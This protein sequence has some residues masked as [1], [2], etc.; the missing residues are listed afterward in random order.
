MLKKKI[1]IQRSVSWLTNWSNYTSEHAP[2]LLK[3][4]YSSAVWTVSH[5]KANVQ[6]LLPN[7]YDWKAVLSSA[8]KKKKVWHSVTVKAYG[9]DHKRGYKHAGH[10]NY[11]VVLCQPKSC[12][13]A[14]KY[15]T[16]GQKSDRETTSS[17][18]NWRE[19]RPESHT[20][21]NDAKC[22]NVSPCMHTTH[23]LKYLL[24]ILKVQYVER[25]CGITPH[26]DGAFLR[27]SVA[28]LCVKCLEALGWF[29]HILRPL[30]S[31]F[32]QGCRWG[33]G[34]E[35]WWKAA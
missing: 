27:L 13:H 22:M 33:G 35:R 15:I 9:T 19:N 12:D 28:N 24:M 5:L 18:T 4:F 32:G 6:G 26:T 20:Q 14:A 31:V 3:C 21:S 8:E 1:N 10:Q 2:V 30:C 17:M 16:E 23:W 7:K 29:K 11:R 34:G 25:N